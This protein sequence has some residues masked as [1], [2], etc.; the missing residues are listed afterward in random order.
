MEIN[1]QIL[2]KKKLLKPRSFDQWKC[3]KLSEIPLHNVYIH[4]ETVQ[5]LFIREF[6]I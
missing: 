2:S 6:H 1:S 4:L 3:F 5:V